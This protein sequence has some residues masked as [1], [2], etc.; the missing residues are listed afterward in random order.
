MK[1]KPLLLILLLLTGWVLT[2]LLIPRRVDL[3]QFAPVEVARLDGEMWRSYYEKKPLQLF[4]QSA[5]LLREQTKAPFWRSF[6]M[7][8]HAAKA[9]FIFK[10]GR[11]R[12]DYNRA[13]PDLEAFYAAIGQLSS[14]PLNVNATARNELEWW[15]IRRE[16]DQHPPAEWASLQAR[17]AADLY[18]IPVTTCLNYGQLRTA[19]MLLRDQKGENITNTD[20][21]RI[22][23][24]LKQAWRSLAQS[25][26]V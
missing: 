4:W 22:Q 6:V 7:A 13:L 16:R 18:H 15:I 26:N 5:K 11:S 21:Q 1:R 17:I 20:W 25:I 23:L 2:D 8:Y 24:L 9:A 10:D 19:A 3:R 12:A 14:Q